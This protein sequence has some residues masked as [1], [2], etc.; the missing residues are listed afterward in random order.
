MLNNYNVCMCQ[1]LEKLVCMLCSICYTFL[2][3]VAFDGSERSNSITGV[4][5]SWDKS[6]LLKNCITLLNSYSPSEVR[7]LC[8]GELSQSNR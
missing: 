2:A 5:K 3:V 1:E 6:F 4:L 8:L 7:I